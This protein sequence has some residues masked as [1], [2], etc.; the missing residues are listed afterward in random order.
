MQ[1]LYIAFI[2]PFLHDHNRS[3]IYYCENQEVGELK[4]DRN[5]YYSHRTST[6]IQESDEQDTDASLTDDELCVMEKVRNCLSSL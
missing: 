2:R 4:I 1:F 3:F 5:D 6:D